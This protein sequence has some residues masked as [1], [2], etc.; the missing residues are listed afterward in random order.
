MEKEQ[1]YVALDGFKVLQERQ[2]SKAL[3]AN[4]CVVAQQ[5]NTLVFRASSVVSQMLQHHKFMFPVQIS[6]NVLKAKS[7]DVMLGNVSGLILQLAR[8]T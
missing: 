3:H 8:T 1:V 2:F 5:Y 6:T 7:I 4:I